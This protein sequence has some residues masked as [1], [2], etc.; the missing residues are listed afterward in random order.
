MEVRRDRHGR[1]VSR[2]GN[3][4][5]EGEL[6][7][8]ELLDR[9]VRYLVDGAVIGTRVFVDRVFNAQPP[10]KRGKRK[11]GARKM[12]GGD[13]GDEGLYSLRDLRKDVIGDRRSPG[14]G[15]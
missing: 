2:V 9:Q 4:P 14:A 15:Q 10:E 6:G 1:G 7:L 12:R 3:S 11:T 13:W 8:R 5:R